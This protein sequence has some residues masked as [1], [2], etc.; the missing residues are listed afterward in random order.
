MGFFDKV[1]G[2][3]AFNSSKDYYKGARKKLNSFIT[4]SPEKHEQVSTLL[5][6]QQGLYQ[7]AVN[8][9]MGPGAGGAFGNAADYYYGNLSNNPADFEAFAAPERRYFNEDI[10]PGLAEQFAGMGS[11]GLSS[12]GFMNAGI[13]AGTDLTERLAQIRANLRS[14]SAQGLQNIGGAGLGRY[15]QDVMTQPGTQG[16]LSQL[17][18]LIGAGVGFAAG[19]PAGGG[20]GYQAGS[21]VGKNTSP[22]GRQQ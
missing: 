21:M 19:G 20:L 8:A 2:V 13:Q 4:G 22:Y 1:P 11:G 14:Q 15:S 16:F 17:A 12:S 10:I 7:Q 3:Q 18:P 6:E 9:G 5:P